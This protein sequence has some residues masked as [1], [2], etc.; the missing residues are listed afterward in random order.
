M[1]RQVV[2]TSRATKN[3]NTRDLLNLLHQARGF[4]E[5]DEI[6][7]LLI[8]SNGYFMQIIEGTEENIED[9][10]TRLARDTMHTNIKVISDKFINNRLFA[11]WAMGCADFN[12]PALAT[13]PGVTTD[14]NDATQVQR[15]LEDILNNTQQWHAV[16]QAC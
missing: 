11:D 2:Y 6:S 3:L 9:L 14:F 10:V 13:L 4:N 7:G 15:L 12:D 1:L 8:H 5:V 16:L